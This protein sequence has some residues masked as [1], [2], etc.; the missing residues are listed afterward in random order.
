MAVPARRSRTGSSGFRATPCGPPQARHEKPRVSAFLS[1]KIDRHPGAGAGLRVRLLRPAGRHRVGADPPGCAGH[2]IQPAQ[3]RGDLRDA[4]PGGRDGRRN[5]RR[6]CMRIAAMQRRPGRRCVLPLHPDCRA[7]RGC[8]SRSGTNHCI[9][10]IRW[11]SEL[12]GSPAATTAL[13]SS[14]ASRWA[15]TASSPTRRRSCGVAPTSSSAP[16]AARNSGPRRSRRARAGRKCRRCAMA[17]SSRS[18]RPTSCSP[19]P[20]ALTDGV[21]QL[22]PHHP[23]LERAPWMNAPPPR[24]G[25]YRGHFHEKL[26]PSQRVWVIV[27]YQK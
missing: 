9:S 14:P 5:R 7:A 21:A 20:A 26:A 11:V 10:A 13:P 27:C 25:L 19:G 22:A 23:G 3:R 12:V 2:G 24:E 18:S 15:R 16:G 17:S 6:A 4:V 8:F 1:A